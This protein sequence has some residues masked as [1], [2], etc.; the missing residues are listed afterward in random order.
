MSG[1]PWEGQVEKRIQ[2]AALLPSLTD[3]ILC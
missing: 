3:L 2:L 1:C